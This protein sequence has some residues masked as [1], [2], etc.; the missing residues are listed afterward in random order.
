MLHAITAGVTKNNTLLLV[1]LA[2]SITDPLKELYCKFN[3]KRRIIKKNFFLYFL[4]FSFTLIEINQK[5]K[6]KE[7]K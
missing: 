4:P 2:V 1:V 7:K 5:S 6:L 3:W